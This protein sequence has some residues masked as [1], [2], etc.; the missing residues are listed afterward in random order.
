MD[1]LP[2]ELIIYEITKHLT[3]LDRQMF[4]T[5]CDKFKQLINFEQLQISDIP[6]EISLIRKHGRF[7]NIFTYLLY[8]E[9]G[10]LV[11][12]KYLIENNFPINHNMIYWVISHGHID[13]LKYLIEIMWAVDLFEIMIVA[14]R[15]GQLDCLK[16]LVEKNDSKIYFLCIYWAARGGHINC[17]KY[18]K[19]I[20]CKFTSSTMA[21]AARNGH[22]DCLKYLF[23]NGCPWTVTATKYATM[24]GHLDCL[25]WLIENGC[26]FD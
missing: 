6:K 15:C 1:K 8:L 9:N 24:G 18:M 16:Y 12:L 3:R 11:C 17:L 13:C 2:D 10:P 20:G 7:H 21:T 19:E 4:R 5:I 26:P 22:L 23:D 14:A 25:K